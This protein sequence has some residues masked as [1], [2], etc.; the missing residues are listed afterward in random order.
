MAYHY[1][2]RVML[3]AHTAQNP[4]EAEW[5]GYCAL[6]AEVRGELRGVLVYTLGGGPNSKQREQCRV[7]IENNPS[8]AAIMC[9]S[10]VVRGIITS[11]NWFLDNRLM[12]FSLHDFEGALRYVERTAGP[13]DRTRYR[14]ELG[15]LIDRLERDQPRAQAR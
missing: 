5:E 11:L 4:G 7:A 2:D 15:A 13:L 9:G 14:R 10:A 1:V 12:A 3:L 6:M 8:G